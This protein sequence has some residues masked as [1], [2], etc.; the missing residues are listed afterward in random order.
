VCWVRAP[1]LSCHDS[2]RAALLL[3]FVLGFLGGTGFEL[4][5]LSLLGRCSTTCT[6]AF[7]ASVI[8]GIGS[9][10]FI[11]VGLEGDPSVY[12]PQTAG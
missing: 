11:Q 8:L 4:R 3:V 9:N 10:I 1:R 12:A 5:A 7:S 6:P 2:T